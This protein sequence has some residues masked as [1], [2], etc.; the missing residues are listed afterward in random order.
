VTRRRGLPGPDPMET[1]DAWEPA[2]TAWRT[3]M[4]AAGR[5]PASIRLVSHYVRDFARTC[6]TPQEAT[7][8]D[9]VTY[10][11][12]DSWSPETRK[13]ARTSVRAFFGWA[14]AEGLL[15]ADP[16]AT[17]PRIRIPAAEPRP[18]AEED[19]RRA[20]EVADE[21]VQL[22]IMLGAVAGLRRAEIAGVHTCDLDDADDLVVLG[23]GGAR[24]TITLPPTL[25]AAI[26]QRPPG[27]L[28]PGPNGPMTPAAVGKLIHRALPDGVTPHML[29]HAAATALHDLG[30]S[31]FELQKFLGH[32]N[33]TVTARYV[34]VRSERTTAALAVRA[35]ALVGAR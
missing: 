12:R 21:R 35:A 18:A 17:L 26:R 15:E 7:R 31:L 22:M 30:L 9:L 32:S 20:L 19:I 4:R 29:R 6:P 23:K 10:L 8:R 28:F 14:L 1:L 34:R 3:E 2:V 16:A 11:S 25:A 5:S 27:W 24:R 13:G 33:P